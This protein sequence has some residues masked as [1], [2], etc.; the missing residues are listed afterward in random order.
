MNIL[1]T[2]PSLDA[3]KNVSGVASVTNAII[4]HNINHKY[5][6]YL[7]GSPDKRLSKPL[8]A[9]ELIK[10]ILLFPFFLRKHK[11]DIVHQ[12]LP[13]N[14]KGLI[15]E[16]LIN[17]WCRILKVPVFLHIH[18]GEFLMN[19]T[20]SL[21][22]RILSNSIFKNSSEVVVLSELE[23]IAIAE[24]YD[25]HSAKVLVNCVDTSLY[26]NMGKKY[27][28]KKPVLLFLGR[29]HE[30]KGIPDLIEALKLL[31]KKF[32]FVFY[33]CGTGPLKEELITSCQE[34]LGSDFKYWGIV[35]GSS[36][37]DIIKDSDYFLLPSRYGEGLP[38]ALLESMASGVVPIVTDDASMKYVVKDGLNGIKV[39]K[40]DPNSIFE[41]LNEIINSSS[42]YEFLSKSAQKEVQEKYDIRNYILQLNF[43]YNEIK[44]RFKIQD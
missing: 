8:W 6:H 22:F 7:L 27:D 33:L 4:S 13:F 35:S 12:N 11:I 17:T 38:I 31:K 19:K 41:R 5:H 26:V 44:V 18:G 14:P 28:P 25:F 39:K 21:F 15:R 34:L 10:Q 2:A 30:S 32:D 9:L 16:Y 3:N 29:I 24:N 1:I 43:I 20:N 23:K 36:K 40:Y 37:I 42:S